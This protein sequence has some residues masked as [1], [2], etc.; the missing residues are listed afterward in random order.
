MDEIKQQKIELNKD[1]QNST[2]KKNEN[3]RHNMTLSVIDRIYQF[4][5]YTF[6]SNKEP[7]QLKLPQYVRASKESFNEILNINN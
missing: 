5:E 7:D 4:F 6:L 2:N 1:G 3:Y